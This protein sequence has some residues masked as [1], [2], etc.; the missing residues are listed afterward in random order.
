MR[1]VTNKS[2]STFRISFFAL[3]LFAFLAGSAF[4]IAGN[5]TLL[6]PANNSNVSITN[7]TQAFVLNYTGGINGTVMCD[8]IIDGVNS[9]KNASVIANATTTFYSNTTLNEGVRVW[10]VNCT[11]I[12]GGAYILTATPLNLRV[13]RTSPVTTV[14]SPA[15]AAWL[16]NNATNF[17]VRVIDS[18]AAN[19]LTCSLYLNGT[20]VTSIYNV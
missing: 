10:T 20:N 1:G 7:F 4:A 5:V 11:N 6:S 9:S 17:T 18:M 16:A 12:T 15:D 14:V 2:G 3:M 8:L 13:D 19:T